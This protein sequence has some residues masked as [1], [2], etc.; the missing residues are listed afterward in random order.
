MLE[1]FNKVNARSKT[2]PYSATDARLVKQTDYAG[3]KN[4]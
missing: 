1:V 3:T 4:F 2:M